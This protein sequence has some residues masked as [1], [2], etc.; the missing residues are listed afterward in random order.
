MS[1]SVTLITS[2][3]SCDA[4]N[5]DDASEEDEDEYEDDGRDEEVVECECEPRDT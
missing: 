2:I 4:K 5:N 3:A 1:E